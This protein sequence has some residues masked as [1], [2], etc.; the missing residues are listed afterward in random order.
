MFADGQLAP[1]VMKAWQANPREQFRYDLLRLIREGGIKGASSLARSV[2]LDKKADDNHR[3]VAAQAA[4]ACEDKAT[5]TALA[6]ELVKDAAKTSP[7]RA[8]SLSLIL[9][10]DFLSTADLLKIIANSKKP[11]EHAAEGFGYELD[12]LYDKSPNAAARVAFLGGLADLCLSK[13]FL[14]EFHRIAK[15][16]R[17]IA[18]TFA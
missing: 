11:A 16:L 6:K 3:I 7:G 8:A 9:Y 13:P 2:A 14:D 18:K 1:T 5:L 15:D 17:E 4:E 12:R 10:P